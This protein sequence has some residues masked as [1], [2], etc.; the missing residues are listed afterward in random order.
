MK[1][2]SLILRGTDG[3]VYFARQLATGEAYR[4]P[5]LAGMTIDVSVPYDFQVFV[6]GQSKG[7][8]PARQVL[9]S[10]LAAAPTAAPVVSAPRPAAPSA[11]PAAVAPAPQPAQP[12]PPRP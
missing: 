10:K 9:A 3:A 4:V 12:A 7:V 5:N 8:L 11:P 6:N 2:A 1:G